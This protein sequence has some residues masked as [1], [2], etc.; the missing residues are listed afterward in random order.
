MNDNNN[1]KQSLSNPLQ[2]SLGLLADVDI[3]SDELALADFAIDSDDDDDKGLYDKV[4]NVQ[5]TTATAN[6]HNNNE[7]EKVETSIASSTTINATNETATE[8][9]SNTSNNVQVTYTSP[10]AVSTSGGSSTPTS[11]STS[12]QLKKETVNA[13][14]DPLSA[15]LTTTNSSKMTPSQPNADHNYQRS[16]TA[17]SHNVY[18]HS[19]NTTITPPMTSTQSVTQTLSSTF[20][21]FAS[22]FQDAMTSATSSSGISSND[23]SNSGVNGMSAATTAAGMMG[24]GLSSTSSNSSSYNVGKQNVNVSSPTV[25]NGSRMM[26]LQQQQQTQQ[27]QTQTQGQGT[28]PSQGPI[29]GQTIY[30]AGLGGNGSMNTSTTSAN[31]VGVGGNVVS[32]IPD[33]DNT[34][35][36]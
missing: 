13:N 17:G 36:S 14:D 31:N 9:I 2:E 34:M 33:L 24:G 11:M 4:V 23:F 6:N 3:T 16:N 7:H 5:N 22:K 28:V 19:N 25:Y 18:S 15:L 10:I 21:S 1:T 8:T 20:S 30:Q 27:Q 26:M 29:Q 32:K 12:N 35:K